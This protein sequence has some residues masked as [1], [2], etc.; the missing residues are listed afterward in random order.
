M[1]PILKKLSYSGF[2]LVTIIL[3]SPVQA[4]AAWWNP[5]DWFS[6]RQEVPQV[7]EQPVTTTADDNEASLATLR[8][9]NSALRSQIT[10]LLKATSQCKLSASQQAVTK[11]ASAIVATPANSSVSPATTVSKSDAE[12]AKALRVELARTDKL[13]LDTDRLYSAWADTHSEAD[14]DALLE[15]LKN[16]KESD[17]TPLFNKVDF[18]PTSALI[19]WVGSDL[20]VGLTTFMHSHILTYRTDLK[21]DLAQYPASES[22]AQ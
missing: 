18:N 22:P 14:R 16:T 8:D 12:K 2:V 10:E 1:R 15:F 21:I 4:Q 19:A 13:D 7:Q 9:E 20:K 17:G 3:F 6:G 5:L 11:K